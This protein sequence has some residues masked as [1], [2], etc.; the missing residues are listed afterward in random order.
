MGSHAMVTPPLALARSASAGSGGGQSRRR[1]CARAPQIILIRSLVLA[2]LALVCSSWGSTP[3]EAHPLDLLPD[4]IDKVRPSVVGVGTAYPPR[5]PLQGAAS[6]ALLGTG[7]A[8]GDGTLVMTNQHVLPEALDE[9]NR[10]TLAVFAGRGRDAQVRPAQLVA[11]DVRHDLA[12]LRISGPPLAPLALAESDPVRE[13]DLVVFTGFPI[14][15]ILGLY[16]VTHTGIVSSI[17]PMAATSNSARELSP[18]QILRMRNPFDVLQLDAIAYP[19]NSGSPVYRPGS[20]EVLGVINSVFVKESR[21]TLLERPSGISYAIPAAH[22]K[23]L[24][25]R[26][27]GYR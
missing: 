9:T 15:A 18:A 24:L 11:E 20:A 12:V 19:G 27:R 6:N 8:V 5:Q 22:A 16:P 26:A 7:F 14:G 2:A 13:G 17:T 1:L 3:A 23:A 21:E 25:D 4:T 10:Q